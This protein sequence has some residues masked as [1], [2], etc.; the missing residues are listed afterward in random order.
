MSSMLGNS[1]TGLKQVKSMERG[2]LAGEYV[3]SGF[4][5][6]QLSNYT[7]EQSKLFGQLFSQVSPESYTGRLA[8]GDE[9]IFNEIEAPAY[10]QFNEQLGGL[11]SRF[12]G[13]GSGGFGSR[14]SSGFQNAGT[15]AASNFAQDLAS[16]RQS[17]RSQAI[18][19]LMGM[20]SELLGQ[21]PND[22]FLIDK[23][24]NQN[25]QGG[26]GSL[27][28]AISGATSGAELGKFAGPWGQGAGALAGAG[29]GFF[30]GK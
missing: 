29:L 19:D 6:A 14:R 7:P 27:S 23:Y 16:Q 10:R 24:G 18:K 25:N 20:S 5:A 21:R 8:S 3:P 1:K 28:G 4:R 30:G 22:R 15:A 26:R 12:S 11:S 13:M 17:L 9:D 2:G